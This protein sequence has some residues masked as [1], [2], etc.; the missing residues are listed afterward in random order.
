MTFEAVEGFWCEVE[1]KGPN[2]CAEDRSATQQLVV[3]L[4]RYDATA[5]P[6]ED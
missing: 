2:D 6:A 1:D 5:M 4:Q 3:L